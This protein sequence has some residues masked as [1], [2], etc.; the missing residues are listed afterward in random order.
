MLSNAAKQLLNITFRISFNYQT[1]VIIATNAHCD[2]LSS[3]RAHKTHKVL[4]ENQ[5][6]VK[7]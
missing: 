7:Q 4:Q 5:E 2:L 1:F 3:T 6:Y